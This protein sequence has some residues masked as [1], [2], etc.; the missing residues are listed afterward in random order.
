[1]PFDFSEKTSISKYNLEIE[2]FEIELRDV[3]H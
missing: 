3:P 2:Y 1:L